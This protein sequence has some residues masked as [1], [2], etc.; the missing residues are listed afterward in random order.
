MFEEFEA[1]ELESTVDLLNQV[2]L[3]RNA[4]GNTQIE[5]KAVAESLDEAKNKAVEIYDA[6]REK[7]P[8]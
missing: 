3:T 8:E 1:K 4:K 5:V 2:K 7:Y 6:L